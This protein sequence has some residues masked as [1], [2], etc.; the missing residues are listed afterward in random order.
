VF[1]GVGIIL[2][3]LL[4]IVVAV[5]MVRGAQQAKDV[6]KHTVGEADLTET[7]KVARK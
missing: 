7:D 3:L 4:L 5:M 1:V 2:L 6:L